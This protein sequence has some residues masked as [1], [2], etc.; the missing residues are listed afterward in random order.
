MPWRPNLHEA[1]PAQGRWTET[2]VL[3]Q[4]RRK[5]RKRLRRDARAVRRSPLR[6]RPP[7][8]RSSAG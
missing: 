6:P 3:R 2:I 1:V 7:G 8:A 5:C 4:P